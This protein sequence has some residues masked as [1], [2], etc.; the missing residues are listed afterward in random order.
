MKQ[1]G[2]EWVGQIISEGT[3]AFHTVIPKMMNVVK[4]N[5]PDTYY[6][7]VKDFNLIEDMFWPD[8]EHEWWQSDDCFFLHEA[9]WFA[10]E[11]IAPNGCSFDS[12]PGDPAC[13]G[14]F[15]YDERNF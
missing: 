12:A 4:D 2:S 7:I 1:L 10:L 11:D 9:L 15:K 3:I 8:D 6:A 13:I 5:D 14:F